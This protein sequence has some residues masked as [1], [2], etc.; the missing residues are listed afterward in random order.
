M[1]W[2]MGERDW[3]VKV[4]GGTE[5]KLILEGDEKEDWRWDVIK[6]VRELRRWS[7]YLMLQTVK[8]NVGQEWLIFI[9]KEITS[10]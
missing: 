2:W 8:S 3:V 4:V 1:R 6:W 9:L 10:F 7:L 5:T